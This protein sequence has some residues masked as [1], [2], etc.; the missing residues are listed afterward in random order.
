MNESLE[1]LTKVEN[2]DK[3][4][5]KSLEVSINNRQ[6]EIELLWKRTTIFWGFIAALFIGVATV[7]KDSSLLA[8]V[9]SNVGLVFSLIWTLSNRGSKSWQESWEIKA[10]HLF[11]KL[12]CKESKLDIYERVVD[13][14]KNEETSRL[15][16]PRMYSLS[17]LLISL[18]DF[19]FVFWLCVCIYLFPG[20]ILKKI[21]IAN[22][23]DV[24]GILFFCFSIGYCIYIII[25][26]RSKSNGMSKEEFIKRIDKKN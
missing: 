10:A 14:K 6:L 19:T 5:S 8:F 4:Y 21:E 7:K 24:V 17:R 20:D 1:K 26:T 2:N 22:L 13:E 3:K 23:R 12:Y 15:L 16:R 9:L 25:A 18:S 11:K